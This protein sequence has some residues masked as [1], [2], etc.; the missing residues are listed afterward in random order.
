MNVVAHHEV[1]NPAAKVE[2]DVEAEFR[3]PGVTSV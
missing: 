3:P 2:F 1:E